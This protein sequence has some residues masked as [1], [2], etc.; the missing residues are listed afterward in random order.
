MVFNKFM[1][2][3]NTDVFLKLKVLYNNNNFIAIL[4]SVHIKANA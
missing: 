2:Q 4:P 1:G 3:V